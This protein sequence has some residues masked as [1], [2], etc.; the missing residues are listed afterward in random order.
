MT[1]NNTIQNLLEQAVNFH[2]DG[3]FL[4]AEKLYNEVLTE[5]SQNADAWHLLGLLMYQQDKLEVAADCIIRATV[6][7][8]NNPFFYNNL[9][10]VLESL[11]RYDEAE[12]TLKKAVEL[13]PDYAEAHNNLGVVYK[14]NN[15]LSEA[16]DSYKQAI[17]LKPD[18]AEAYY[19][20][21]N[22]YQVINR[23][24]EAIGQYDKALQLL[25]NYAEALNNKGFLLYR[26]GQLDDAEDLLKRS[27]AVFKDNPEALNNLGMT[28]CQKKK[29]A[30][31][32][33]FIKQALSLKPEYPE[34]YC[35]L[36][37]VY[38]NNNRLSDALQALQRSVD[39][40]P[41]YGEGYFH[42]ANVLLENGKVDKA[43]ECLQNALAPTQPV[44]ATARSNLLFVMNYCHGVTQEEIY[45]ES[46][47]WAP[48]QKGEEGTQYHFKNVVQKDRKLKIGYVSGDFREH[49]V[50]FFLEPVL[51]SH[52]RE[53]FEIYCYSK[54]KNRDVFTER[55]QF[56]SHHW[57]DITGLSDEE[58]TERVR[59]DRIDILVDLAGHTAEN[60]LA[61]FAFKAAPLQVTWLG[62]PNTTGLAA[63]DYR[64]T[65]AIADPEG[66]DDRF[67]S[68]ERVRLPHGFLCFQPDE[69][70]P[71]IS[72]PPCT[73]KGHITFGSFNTLPKITHQVVKVWSMILKKVPGSR[74]ILK[75][76]QFRF[77]ETRGD[78]R[79]LFN[80]QGIDDS[81]IDMYSLTESRHEHLAMYNQVDICLDS[82]PYN[83]TTT[84]CEALWM[85]VPVITIAGE[86]H[87]G[88]VGASLMHQA[89]LEELVA[90]SIE[91]YIDLAVRM[92]A[93]AES[94][95]EMRQIM[96]EELLGSKLMDR[97]LFTG[98]LEETY[99]QLWGQW[100]D[101][102]GEDL[103]GVNIAL[104]ESADDKTVDI[105][106]PHIKDSYWGEELRYA[107]RSL[108]KNFKEEFRVHIVGYCPSWCKNVDHIPFQDSMEPEL[109]FQN[110]A[111]K[112]QLA[113]QRFERF[114]WTH[115]DIYFINPV[116]LHD[117]QLPRVEYDMDSMDRNEGFIRNEFHRVQWRTYDRLKELQLTGY[118]PGTHLP[119]FYESVKL[120]RVFEL[121]PIKEGDFVYGF[122]YFNMYFPGESHLVWDPERIGCYSRKDFKRQRND[123]GSAKFL[124]HDNAGLS[125][126]LKKRLMEMFSEKSRFEK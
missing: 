1:P 11:K 84:T 39:M 118:R 62:Y 96:R 90:D 5:D 101:A 82:F 100:C 103:A 99:R 13:K 66:V 95:I 59:E 93:D 92:A 106:I 108:G 51:Q 7:N 124:N 31:A 56:L 17:V 44:F 43:R 55:F 65:D 33:E 9:G 47:K 115:D 3:N 123:F 79:R 67:Y 88:R 58:V 69:E 109:A 29:F 24:D 14:S 15:K 105:V 26:K 28:L 80:E 19:N 126:R 57:I 94:L 38:L 119:R 18:Y 77:P 81:R 64:F 42:L 83:G 102:Q 114:V 32:E 40:K 110:T 25:P 73:T 116:S 86:H 53:S 20:L 117:I 72:P 48:V 97:N 111:R 91:E 30:E 12:S 21:G 2:R 36:G 37:I 78:F 125:E 121:F 76:R 104:D 63:M 68:E 71:P 34:A 120:Q 50:A 45:N 6:L 75:A 70:F 61:A 107:L 122:A 49:S 112:L 89:G 98:S 54:V 23:L 87:A 8:P 74:L 27:L 41:D 52:D 16:I 4:E 10:N 113:M 22:A 85:G 46:L 35:N 60:S